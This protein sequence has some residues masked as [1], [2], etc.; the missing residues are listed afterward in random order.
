MF[1]FASCHRRKVSE[2]EPFNE[3]AIAGG[4]VI[5][6][7]VR[8]RVTCQYDLEPAVAGDRGGGDKKSRCQY[9]V[10]RST[11]SCCKSWPSL[12]PATAGFNRIR[13]CSPMLTHGAMILPPAAAGSL[14]LNS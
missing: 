5:A 3:P 10:P 2:R 6:A 13:A 9:R 14:T 12:P 1:A 4:R 11:H 8:V 7:S